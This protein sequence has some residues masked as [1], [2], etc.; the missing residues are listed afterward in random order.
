MRLFIQKLKPISYRKSFQLCA[1]LMSLRAVLS[2]L[3]LLV[4]YVPLSCLLITREG[5]QFSDNMQRIFQWSVRG[6]KFHHLLRQNLEYYVW[7]MY[8]TAT[9]MRKPEKIEVVGVETLQKHLLQ[10]EKRANPLI[11]ITAHL[12]NWE[13]LGKYCSL[14]LDKDFYV[15]AKP[16]DSRWINL[17]I[18][19]IRELFNIKVLWTKKSNFQKGIL[20]VLNNKQCLGFVMDQKPEGR[21]GPK[22]NFMGKPAEFVA[23]PAHLA[24]RYQ[25]P[26]VSV[27]CVRIGFH[28]YRVIS[29]ILLE[30]DHQ[31]SDIFTLTQ[32]FAREVEEVISS[33]PEQWC[34]SYK[35][36]K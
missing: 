3:L 5:K 33:Y 18:D 20:K 9:A 6:E 21:I 10:V 1:C 15:L 35:R 25:C 2:V 22:V 13:L 24:V 8:D 12:G 7:L 19:Y 4:R 34:W 11:M 32:N 30:S 31:Q 14:S 23:G 36:W 17:A 27:F 29:K 26:V 16:L 28:K